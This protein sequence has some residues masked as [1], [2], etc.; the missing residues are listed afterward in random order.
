MWQDMLL[1]TPDH[2]Y[3]IYDYMY[4]YHSN[5]VSGREVDVGGEGSTLKL[6]PGFFH[7]SSTSVYLY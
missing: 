4:N 7:W 6:I 5:D 3:S 1:K 2:R